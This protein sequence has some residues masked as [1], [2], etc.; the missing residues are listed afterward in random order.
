MQAQLS[1]R[2]RDDQPQRG[3]SH[4]ATPERGV[5]HVADVG[6]LHRS[7]LDRMKGDVSGECAVHPIVQ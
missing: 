6:C 7:A 1:E 2:V 4:A 5:D 3:G